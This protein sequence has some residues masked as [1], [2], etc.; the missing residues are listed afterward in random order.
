MD[1]QT[2]GRT[3]KITTPKTALAYARVVKTMYDKLL[4]KSL[5]LNNK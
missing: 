5:G 2:D 1:R 4:V 3:D